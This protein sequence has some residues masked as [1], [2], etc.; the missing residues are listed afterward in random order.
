MKKILLAALPLT[1]LFACSK[2]HT[3]VKTTVVDKGDKLVTLNAGDFLKKYQALPRKAGSANGR[4]ATDSGTGIVD[5]FY[6]IDETNEYNPP[7]R[8]VHQHVGDPSFGQ[9][10]FNAH[11]GHF[12]VHVTATGW[13]VNVDTSMISMGVTIYSTPDGSSGEQTQPLGELFNQN[14][15]FDFNSGDSINTNLVLTRPGSFIELHLTD[16]PGGDSLQVSQYAGY[17]WSLTSGE[18]GGSGPY[19]PM[20]KVAP[21]VYA[22]FAYSMYPALYAIRLVYPD[23]TTGETITRDVPVTLQPNTKITV[24]G[25]VYKNGGSP[26]GGNSGF[27]VAVDT[28][29]S[30]PVQ[31]N[32]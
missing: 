4:I 8:F 23:R 12:T 24:T 28:A 25:A 6:S 5:L 20:N 11:Y 19:I 2:E 32:F 30:A 10:T 1:I 3:G 7:T 22:N 26:T 14:L 27:A 18:I 15:Q 29:W 17:S 16:A 21:G 9:L 13:P 31:V